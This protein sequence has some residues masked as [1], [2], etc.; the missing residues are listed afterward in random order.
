[1]YYYPLYT[2]VLLAATLGI[3][4][5]WWNKYQNRI[6]Y[7]ESK[8]RRIQR[9]NQ[10]QELRLVYIPDWQK[11]ISDK[12]AVLK[13]QLSKKNQVQVLEMLGSIENMLY[14]RIMPQHSII[15]ENLDNYIN[16]NHLVIQDEL[17]YHREKSEQNRDPSMQSLI[18]QTIKNLEDKQHILEESRKELIYFYTQL[19]N[20]LQQLDNM[21]LKSSMLNDDTQLLLDLKQDINTAFEGFNDANSLLDAISK[22]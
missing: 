18:N 13:E 11:T 6:S 5:R 22:I 8:Q 15:E 7:E 4:W 2:I 1:M 21:R 17:K 12:I 3:S 19:N 16:T 9:I 10:Y 14:E 20:I